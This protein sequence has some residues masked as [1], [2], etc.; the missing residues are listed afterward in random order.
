MTTRYPVRIA[1][2]IV[3]LDVG[4]A[5]RFLVRLVEAHKNNPGFEHR[6]ISLTTKGVL[7]PGL[8]KIGIPVTALGMRNIADAPSVYLRLVN[9]LRADKP[10]VLQ[11]WMYYADL[12][13]GLA[14]RQLGMKTI[15][16][17]I[18]N[19]HF[20]SGG[21]R[22]KRLIRK[23]CAWLSHVVPSSIV[24]VA[25]SARAVH[26]AAGYDNTR[27]QVIHNG[28]DPESFQ[29]SDMARQSL[30]REL[31][32][33]DDAIVIGSVGRY[34][35]AKDHASFVKAAAIAGRDRSNT[36]FLL[37][38]REL[39]AA[40]ETL[41]NLIDATGFPERF[42]L[43]GER[44]DIAACMSAMDIFCLHSRTEGF[45]NVLGEAMCIGLPCV[46]TDVGDASVL[47]GRTGLVI[48]KDSVPELAAGLSSMLHK[49]GTEREALGVL[50]RRRIEENF[51][52]AHAV[53]KF[54]ML[55]R[56]QA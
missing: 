17:G 19:S 42:I 26:E 50:A 43:L 22:L 16:W 31:T 46:T 35:A 52:L 49:P 47:L 7:G 20:E 36:Y 2:V 18:R 13:G 44:P 40:N 53:E 51:T 55:Y 21:T 5:E 4:G 27:M 45:P 37:V 32:V 15:L 3:G 33:P 1:H 54:E 56:P 12:L 48:R 14:G 11:C 24:C 29:Y 39:T 6:V 23:T 10:D 38:G 34:S 30:R 25:E 28:Y 41:Q 8:E 9:A